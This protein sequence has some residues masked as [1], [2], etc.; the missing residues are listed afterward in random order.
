MVLQVLYDHIWDKSKVLTRQRVA[1]ID[2]TDADVVKVVT[3]DGSTFT[4]D[5]VVGADGIHSTVRREMAR[6]DRSH[7]YLEEKGGVIP[8]PHIMQQLTRPVLSA[9]YATA[10]GISVGETGIAPGSV[11]NV[12]NDKFSYLITGGPEKRTYWFLTVDMGRTF[13]GPDIPRFTKK[14]EKEL[15]AKH[16]DDR[17]TPEVRFGDIYSRSLPSS[18]YTALQE[19]AYTRWHFDRII[20]IGDA[21]HKVESLIASIFICSYR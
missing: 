10:F 20:A 15:V 5:I 6:L 21:S 17:I 1:T 2:I 3:T 11:H 4:G 13:Y 8:S 16:L 12:Y 19:N 18:V 14:D 9:T 7:D